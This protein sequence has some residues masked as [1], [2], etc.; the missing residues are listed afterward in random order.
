MSKFYTLRRY[1]ILLII[2]FIFLIRPNVSQA[3][4][5]DP[6]RIIIYDIE[7]RSEKNQSN[8]YSSIIPTSFEK[9]FKSNKN[10]IIKLTKKQLEVFPQHHNKYN[11]YKS[12]LID[13]AKEQNADC[14]LSGYYIAKDGE[15][16]LMFYAYFPHIDQIVEIDCGQ[17][18]IGIFLSRI[19]DKSIKIIRTTLEK[20]IYRV[21]KPV[22]HPKIKKVQFYQDVSIKSKTEKSEIY[23]TDDGD[24]PSK[25]DGEEYTSSFRIRR[26]N[27]TIKAIGHRKRWKYSPIETY[28]YQIVDPLSNL[29]IGVDY[30]HMFFL[31]KWNKL[32]EKKLCPI[33]TTYSYFQLANIRSL[34]EKPFVNN[35]GIIISADTAYAKSSNKY[36]I[37]HFNF[38]GVSGGLIY[39]LRAGEF[40]DFDI[41]AQAGYVK[42]VITE[43][44]F[45]KGL[46]SLAKV[47]KDN[48]AESK[49]T[50]Y[51][52]SFFANFKYS[53]LF[54]RG[55][56]SIKRINY[57]DEPMNILIAQA[58]VGINFF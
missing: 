30:G 2:S 43:D 40:L 13:K 55:G 7:N 12:K 28:T 3:T 27:T 54:L 42:S 50:Y 48:L 38:Y 23:Y 57:T 17:N 9:E 6:D 33:I 52:G 26:N 24:T 14:V 8:Y 41:V 46:G 53:S 21:R 18:N 16:Y 36:L 44:K 19:I 15:I 32:I 37:N 35:L 22:I 49:D 29:T 51:T 1:Y 5:I 39:K 4:L 20:N 58:G 25:D 56:V 47:P 45:F 11:A 31:G 10:Y 34:K